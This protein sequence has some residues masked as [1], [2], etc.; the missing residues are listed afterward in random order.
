MA[1]EIASV[2]NY[3]YIQFGIP[4]GVG[5]GALDVVRLDG[6]PMYENK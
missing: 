5:V 4:V 2:L 6:E 1:N 3:M